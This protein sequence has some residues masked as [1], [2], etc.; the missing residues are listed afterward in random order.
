M[1]KAAIGD[2]RQR[3]FAFTK[4]TGQFPEGA[5]LI[6]S[7][8]EQGWVEGADAAEVMV[9]RMQR[10]GLLAMTNVAGRGGWFGEFLVKFYLP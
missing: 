7:D 6:G 4:S 1:K 5:S 10:T 9:R 3:P 8:C 2:I